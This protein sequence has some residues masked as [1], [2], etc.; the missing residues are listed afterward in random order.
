MDLS[1]YIDFS[2][3]KNA[4]ILI[5]TAVILIAV[6]GI[7]FSGAY[8]IMDRVND[9]LLSTTCVI[10]N[11]VF[12]DNCQD[13]WTMVIYPFLAAKYIL[14]YLSFFFIIALSIGM[15][16]FGYQSGTKPSMLGLLVVIEIMITYGSIP[17][18]NIYRTL[19]EN[20]IILEA[21]TPFTVYNK[22]MLNFPWFVFV[23]SLFALSLG[24]VNWQRTPVNTPT[25]ELD[26]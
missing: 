7:F 16:L 1:D 9:A 22:I 8:L 18:A 13:M 4:I 3:K 14:V 23:L 11:N 24:I 26:F 6:S 5:I 19:L 15:L 2:S 17:I 25:N 21:L 20:P 12:F 10:E